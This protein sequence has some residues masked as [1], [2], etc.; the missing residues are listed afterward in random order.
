MS[1]FEDCKNTKKQGDIGEARAIYEYTKLGY[2]I[3]APLCD[4][5]KYD[6]IIEKDGTMR[7]VQVK[8][9]SQ[10]REGGFI[11]ELSTCGGNQS[12]NSRTPRL[13]GDYDELFV[14]LSDER[15][16]MIPA[17][18]L[19]DVKYSI[20]VGNTKWREFEIS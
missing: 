12:R 6:L 1:L 19:E 9:S 17:E 13:R 2:V 8:T 10:A 16:W 7:R 3:C 11:I 14:L 18:K 4:S 15:R 5:A 20:K